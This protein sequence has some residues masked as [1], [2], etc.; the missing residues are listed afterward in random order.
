MTTDAGQP[1][2]PLS[3]AT[4]GDVDAGEVAVPQYDRTALRTGIVHFGVGGFHRAHQ[5]MYLDTLL[6][7]GLAA[8]WAIC[9]VGLLPPDA[10]MA[11]VMADQDC[12]YTLI[13][14]AP[15][16]AISARVIGSITSYLFAPHD[17]AAV[18]DRLIDPDVRIVTMT[19]TESGYNMHR[20]SGEFVA[21]GPGIADDLAQPD[22]PK[23]VFGFVTEALAR[24]RAAGTDP[25]TV[26]SCDNLPG[27][28]TVCR[29]AIVGFAR[30][31][32]PDLAD[33]IDTHVSFPNSM[34][35]R[36]TPATSDD[37][38]AIARD[39]FGIADSWPVVC[40]PFVQWVL[41][42]D[43]P[44]G[45]PP[46]ERA[47]VQL[48][49][50]V[51]PY[52][53]MK[54]RLLNASHQALG[55]A[56]YLAGYRYVHEAMADPAFVALV[57]DYMRTEAVGSLRPVPGIDLDGYIDELL[58]RF[59]NPAIRD[60]LARL[61]VDSS[62]R[63]PKFLLP[64][65]R[66]QLANGGPIERSVTVV[67]CW[68]RWC[69]AVDEAG[70]PIEIVDPARDTLVAAAAGR[71]DDP[72]SFVRNA[73][74]FGDLADDERFAQSYRSALDSVYERGAGATVAALADERST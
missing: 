20:V 2:V 69:D 40:E 25:F 66:H 22:R 18:L 33:W 5:A 29:R 13:E 24:R 70:A 64:V 16:G 11:E 45:R 6:A 12:L 48:V 71:A 10:R 8:D 27:N 41:E 44:A 72:L 54:L 55:Y 65:L 50:D 73:D 15:D 17:P 51:E 60:T 61:C 34:V 37:D 30:L 35:D 39:R 23:T 14:K 68:A 46:L 19:V 26:V 59:T 62:E 1:P 63:M 53:L 9:G 42:D 74:I 56:G 43:F 58:E 47:G 4:L 28:G 7:D 36:I 52:E 67:A 3:A 38:R 49:P 21:D 32:D 57:R 31:R